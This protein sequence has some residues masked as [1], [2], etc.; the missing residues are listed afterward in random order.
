MITI[1]GLK[2]SHGQRTIL[3]SV[4]L[5]LQDG[6]IGVI[7][8]ASG[9]GKTTLLRC[10]SGLESDYTGQIWIG[11]HE[12]LPTTQ[13]SQRNLG[14]L[15]Q[16]VTLFPQLNVVKNIEL[17]LM[18]MNPNDRNKR[19]NEVMEICEISKYALSLPSQL[20][21]GEQQ[22]VALARSIAP[23][24]KL[25]IMDE[26]FSSLDPQ[27]RNRLRQEIKKLLKSLKITCLMVSHDIHEAYMM[28]DQMGILIDGK[29]T[30]WSSGHDLYHH[31]RTPSI[32]SY[33]DTAV[34]LSVRADQS[35]H[36]FY[37]DTMLGMQSKYKN[38]SDLKL[39]LRPQHVLLDESSSFQATFIRQTFQGAQSLCE[40]KAPDGTT[41][42]ALVKNKQQLAQ[43]Q[44]LGLRFQLDHLICFEQK[45]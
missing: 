24:P 44:H 15:F 38:H 45:H 9:S 23:N 17:A 8:G 13:P 34:F 22:R 28:S 7:L 39:L 32:A 30:Q 35:G 16:N 10:I 33:L 36:V 26:P 40:L 12:I 25:I 19:A 14:Y 31:P 20:S 29:I 42:F 37:Q 2:K 27:L 3:E 21:G 41:L 4:N 6:E 1:S 5:S 18:K 43:G 11:D